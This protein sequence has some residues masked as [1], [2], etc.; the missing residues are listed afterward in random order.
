MLLVE[1]KRAVER[2]KVQNI[3]VN[4]YIEKILSLLVFIRHGRH[5]AG[6]HRVRAK[7]ERRGESKYQAHIILSVSCKLCQ[8]F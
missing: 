3:H 7:L 1:S 8:T 5:S 2:N 6:C 4:F